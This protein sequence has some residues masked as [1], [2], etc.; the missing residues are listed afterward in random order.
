MYSAIAVLAWPPGVPGADDAHG[1]DARGGEDED[2]LHRAGDQGAAGHR[3]GDGRERPTRRRRQQ[4][5]DEGDGA[6]GHEREQG[7]LQPRQ[8]HAEAGDEQLPRRR[9]GRRRR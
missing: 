6:G 5:P 2:R 4:R 7:G 3:G 9:L 8:V 1:G